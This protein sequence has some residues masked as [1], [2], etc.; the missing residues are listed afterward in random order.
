MP[1]ICKFLLTITVTAPTFLSFGL[2]GLLKNNDNY[3]G[4]SIKCIHLLEYNLLE[5]ALYF[6]IYV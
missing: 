2:I 4:T 6:I 3:I 5:Y 1:N